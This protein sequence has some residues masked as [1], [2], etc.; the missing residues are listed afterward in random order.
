MSTDTVLVTGGF[1]LVG[2][3]VVSRLVEE[4]RHVVATDLDLTN[5]RKKARGL[6]GSD[7]VEVRWVDLTDAGAVDTLVKGVDPGAIVHL[8]AVIPPACYARR[9]LARM[10]NVD[11]TRSLVRAASH[12]ARL[13]RGSSWRRASR[14]T[15]LATHTAA[16][17]C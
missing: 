17:P 10:V 8:A 9:N 15:A 3:V 16:P 4:G 12:A 2:T 13:R 5:N 7:Q 6:L 14:S 1:G 11:A